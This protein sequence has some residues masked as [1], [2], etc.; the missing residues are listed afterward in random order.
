MAR[1]VEDR[2]K[3]LKRRLVLQVYLGD[4][5][6]WENVKRARI[7]QNVRAEAGL[8]PPQLSPPSSVND[9]EKLQSWK[10]SV[11]GVWDL[12][13]PRAFQE[14]SN[15][16][17]FAAACILYDP[18]ELQLEEF[19]QYGE[20]VP[21][22][23]KSPVAKQAS[24]EAAR[25]TGPAIEWVDSEGYRADII[26]EFYRGVIAELGRRYI[27]PQGEGV[28]QAI[29]EIYK[30]TGLLDELRRKLK[31]IE[32]HPYIAVD[33]HTPEEDI[34]IAARKIRALRGKKLG[35]KPPR[36]PLVAI[37]CAAL[38]HDHNYQQPEDKRMKRWSYEHLVEEL[39][40]DPAEEATREDPRLRRK[41]LTRLGKNYVRLGEELRKERLKN[42][43]T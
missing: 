28:W 31:Q 25:V 16:D 4:G 20:S 41:R 29:D 15:W 37:K 6:F 17:D 34:L 26:E 43:G 18:P 9:P 39:K 12:V 13:V 21:A 19:A 5:P 7:V 33:K 3:E 36:D 14:A 42:R 40:L 32:A 27:D 10:S 1:S 8:P 11:R 35:G 30:Q 38:Y 23:S 24:G 2:V 22:G